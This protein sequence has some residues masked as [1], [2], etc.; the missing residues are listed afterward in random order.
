[1]RT[2]A[3]AGGGN[4]AFAAAADLTL[5]GFRV[6]LLE[7]PELAAQTLGPVR[8]RG[9]IELTAVPSTPVLSGFAEVAIVT[10]SAEE[11]LRAADAVLYVVPAFAERRFTELCLLHLRP[12]QMVVFL[13]GNLGAAMAFA[14][15]YRAQG[16]APLP[17]VVETDGLVYAAFKSGGAAVRVSGYK[18]GIA[19]AAF[20][21]RGTREALERLSPLFPTFRAAASVLETGLRNLNPIVHAPVSVLNAGRT[22]SDVPRWR[23]YWD[24]VSAE[25]GR[26]VA[27]VDRE[28]LAVA[29]AL[30]LTL[31][32][33]QQV[34][35]EWYSGQ[36]VGGE[37]LAEIMRTNPAYRDVWAPASLD[38][39]FVTEDVPFG[40]V[41]IEA[42]GMLADVAT[43]VT[44]AL[45]SLAGHLLGRDFRREGRDLAALGL[46]GMRAQDLRR[47]VDEGQ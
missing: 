13:C 18:R 26:V 8:E 25:V 23:Y 31:P 11:A 7:A 2:V 47:M 27:E 38:H 34:L 12:Q 35:L 29:R 4:G 15:Q 41:P 37:S 44:T 9:G 10:D 3:V 30:G 1:M 16:R 20:P 19:C 39:R 43:P 24:G 14:R 46:T 42:L 5:R 22:R 36:G 28:R 6:H 45:I 21:A 33:A 32:S 17:L 40:L